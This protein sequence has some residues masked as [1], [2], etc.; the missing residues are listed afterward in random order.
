MGHIKRLQEFLGREVDNSNLVVFRIGFGFLLLAECWGAI[1]T[2][3]VRRVFMVPDFTFSYIG[4][5]WLQPLGGNG[6]YYYYFLMGLFGLFMMIGFAYRFSSVMFCLL[7]LGSYLM[8]KSSYNNHYYLLILLS[9]L[10]AFLPA[11]KAYSVD[12]K[13]G[14]TDRKETAAYGYIFLFIAQVAIVYVFASINKIYPDWLQAKPVAIWFEIKRNYFLIGPLLQ[15]KW[16]HYFIAYGGIIY[17]GIIVF[18]LLY[19]RTRKL[20]FFLSLFFNLF[21]SAVFQIGIFPYLMIL[22]SVFFYPG[23]SIRKVFLKKKQPVTPTAGSFPKWGTWAMV[24]YL[25]IQTLL[26]LRH[27]FIPGNVN[28]TEEGHKYSWRMMLRSKNGSGR[29][30]VKELQSG[31]QEWVDPRDYMTFKQYTRVSTFPDMT[32]QFAQRLKDIYEA[33]GWEEVAVFA[34]F[35]MSLNGNPRYSHIDP[36]VDLTQIEWNFFGHADW[37]ITPE[38]DD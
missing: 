9:G 17:D 7:W 28:W 8:Q 29:Y 32:W 19:H 1:L 13:L 18:L 22:F 34:H 35:K 15:H 33:K 5:E 26:P 10:M 27:W 16:M 25:V 30:L 36:K 24:I 2:G 37:K 21:N 11:H 38:Y 4:F 6:M 14:W 3:W 12:V 31:K 23:E 20:G